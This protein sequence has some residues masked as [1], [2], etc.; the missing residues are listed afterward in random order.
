MCAK[1]K[2]GPGKGKA[3]I[4]QIKAHCPMKI[5]AIDILGP[6]PLTKQNNEYIIV[7]RC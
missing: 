4:Q 7:F 1:S 3:Q 2:P 6:L 5:L